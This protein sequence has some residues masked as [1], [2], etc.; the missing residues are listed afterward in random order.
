MCDALHAPRGLLVTPGGKPWSTVDPAAATPS[1]TPGSSPRSKQPRRPAAFRSKA[2]G[3]QPTSDGWTEPE[4]TRPSCR[5][6]VLYDGWALFDGRQLRAGAPSS[7]EGRSPV[8]P[9][10]DGART[11]APGLLHRPS[12]DQGHEVTRCPGAH[13]GPAPQR[14]PN[15][16]DPRPFHAVDFMPYG[17]ASEDPDRDRECDCD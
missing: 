1:K 9:S 13:D 17:L 7:W 11:L 6:D 15:F 10:L 12:P 5:A 16:V 3:T 4:S 8:P 2:F 14:D